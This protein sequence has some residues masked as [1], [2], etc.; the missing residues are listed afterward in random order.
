[1]ASHSSQSPISSNSLVSLFA[2]DPDMAEL[3]DYFVGELHDRV[4]RLAQALAAGNSDELYVIAHQLK[5]AAGGYGFPS[6][7]ELAAELE[8]ACRATEI[9]TSALAEKVESLID[10]CRR[11]VTSHNP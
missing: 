4:G 7:S 9:E 2:G 5:G 8:A 10:I 3:I 6:I 1:M 11:A